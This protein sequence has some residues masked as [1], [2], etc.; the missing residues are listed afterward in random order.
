MPFIQNLSLFARRLILRRLLLLLLLLHHV[1]IGD[2]IRRLPRVMILPVDHL[3]RLLLLRGLL[4]HCGIDL[5]NN[6]SIFGHGKLTRHRNA[7]WAARSN[8]D[9][10]WVWRRSLLRARRVIIY[11]HVRHRLRR[12]LRLWDSTGRERRALRQAR[13]TA[14]WW[15]RIGRLL[16]LWLNL[17]SSFLCLNVPIKIRSDNHSW[18][19]HTKFGLYPSF[20]WHVSP[21][22][23]SDIPEQI[24]LLRSSGEDEILTFWAEFLQRLLE[25]NVELS[26]LANRSKN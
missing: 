14:E 20:F 2:V 9:G 4:Q 11:R 1:R 22:A 23:T 17:R 21:N 12:L 6:I 25:I 16:V 13:R 26:T 5:K 7:K 19:S 10:C 15:R 24:I 3:L 8:S 18:I